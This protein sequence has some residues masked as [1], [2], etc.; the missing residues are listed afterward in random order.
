MEEWARK[1]RRSGY[2]CTTRH[3]VIR[4][5]VEYEK[6][7]KVEDE[8]GR[9]VH[10][11]REWQQATRRLEKELKPANWHTSKSDG[12][13]ISAPLIVDP[14]NGNLTKKLKDICSKFKTANGINVTVRK[15]AGTSIRSDAK[16]EPLRTKGCDRDDCLVCPSG[17]PGMCENNSV[18]YR[19]TCES[20]LGTGKWLHYE[21]E[22]GRNV[23]SR[24][25]EPG[26][27]KNINCL[28][29]FFK[30]TNCLKKCVV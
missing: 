3:Q 12:E 16:S 10:R 28:Q 5:A 18:G 24:G 21:G 2:H 30:A 22:I 19:I 9:P 4:E 6:M 15:R 25:L 26:I 11:A 14:T 29:D 20:C 27:D 17:K 8:G 13:Q 1:L 7:C 23:Y